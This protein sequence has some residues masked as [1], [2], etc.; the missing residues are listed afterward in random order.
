MTKHTYTHT[1]GSHAC[2]LVLDPLPCTFR[3]CLFRKRHKPGRYAPSRPPG[4]MAWGSGVAGLPVGTSRTQSA[5]DQHRPRRE[6]GAR[7]LCQTMQVAHTPPSERISGNETS[8]TRR[9]SRS[10]AR[11]LVACAG[12]QVPRSRHFAPLAEGL[13][14]LLE[15][16]RHERKGEYH[17]LRTAARGCGA[18]SVRP[19]PPHTVG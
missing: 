5:S 6:L 7:G 12:A 2:E 14:P 1:A 8:P 4:K 9:L 17:S 11:P 16:C 19:T 18:H 13:G 15:V 10:D 3:P